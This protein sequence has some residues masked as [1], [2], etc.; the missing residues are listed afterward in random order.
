[1]NTQ[2]L[3][4]QALACFNQNKQAQGKALM[5]RAAQAGSAA[6][7]L[8]YAD[9]LFK[10]DKAAAYRYL[11]EQWQD[12]V[13]GTLHRRAI[14]R[15]FFDV[16]GNHSPAELFDDLHQEAINGDLQSVIA[17]LSV[18]GDSSN[19][20]YYRILLQQLAPQL[21]AQLLA[22]QNAGGQLIPQPPQPDFDT[23][24][25]SFASGL[26]KWQVFNCANLNT[27]IGLVCAN[28]ALTALEC[29]YMMLRFGALLQPSLIVDPTTGAAKQNPYR[30]GS[31]VAIGPEYL[32]W[33]TLAIEYKMS[34]FAGFA[35][36]QGEVMNLIH[37]DKQQRYLPH[38]DAIIGDSASMSAQLRNGG[39]R[40]LTVLAY[41]NTV[42][43]G[44]ETSFPKLGLKV[45]A[46][47]GDLLMFRNIDEAGQLL[48]ASYH[49][50]EPVLAGDKW[51]LSKWVRQGVTDYGTLAYN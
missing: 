48:Q 27:E 39:Q 2:D 42:P 9:L 46:R 38:F 11:A 37:Y 14:L 8:Y 28:A 31:M 23:L 21:S 40:Q 3:I 4:H 41:L 18:I 17:L 43:A 13:T 19:S 25:Q 10:E 24:R 26:Q 47:A 45:Q 7:V 50:G 29:N 51:L 6:A 33:V 5:L 15:C 44:G 1:M 16:D 34:S 35:R 32:D 12:G 22:G 30:T 49:A 36:Q 20:E